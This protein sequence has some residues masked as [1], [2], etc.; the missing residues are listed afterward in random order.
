MRGESP[1]IIHY[2]H[3]MDRA[4]AFY[5]DVF[6]VEVLFASPGWTTLDFKAFELA[7]H[8]LHGSD[9]SEAPIPH[10]GLNLLVEDIED[11]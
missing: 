5:R 7:L 11:M 8:I 3:D 10:A 2:V 9:L 6:D 4:V 1:I